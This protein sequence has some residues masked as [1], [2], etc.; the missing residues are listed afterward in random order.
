MRFPPFRRDRGSLGS[1]LVDGDDGTEVASGR[2]VAVTGAGGAPGRTFLS[3]NVAAALAAQGL[4]VALLELG[5]GLGTVS[6]QLGLREDRSLSFLSHEA[7][8]REVDEQL[9]FR[10]LQRLGSLRILTGLFEP[11]QQPLRDLDFLSRVLDLV[12]R[13]HQLTVADLG[14]M[15]SSLTSALAQRC[16]AICWVVAP[17]PVGADLFDRVVRASLAAPLR[18]KPNLAVLN[19]VGPGTLPGAEATLPRRYGMPLAATIPFDRQACMRADYTH[20]PAAMAG[21]LRAPLARAAMA[22]SGWAFPSTPRVAQPDAPSQTT[23]SRL[24]GTGS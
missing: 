21:P 3:L 23:S 12:S 13:H 8:L 17:T 10:H 22:V 11:A 5:P 6:S 18:G 16:H 24:I 14:P 15:D 20:S 1:H 9:L 2:I 19:G 7:Q 4:K